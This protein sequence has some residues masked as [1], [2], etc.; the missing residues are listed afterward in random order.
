MKTLT[1]SAHIEP[2]TKTRV[3]AFAADGGRFS[4]PFI[5]LRIG[6]DLV[7]IALIARPG[8]SAALRALATAALEAAGLLDTMTADTSEV[9][10]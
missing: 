9:Q 5:S 10:G 7:E 6:G 1:T 8:T 4:E 2:D 3:T